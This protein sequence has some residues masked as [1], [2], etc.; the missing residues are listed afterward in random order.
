[1]IHGWSAFWRA[2]HG[3]ELEVR[4][5]AVAGAFY[6]RSSTQDAGADVPGLC[7]GAD[8][9]RGSQLARYGATKSARRERL[10]RKRPTAPV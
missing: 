10:A 6:Q 4:S 1:M 5:R 9:R 2:D 8:W 3:R 7:R